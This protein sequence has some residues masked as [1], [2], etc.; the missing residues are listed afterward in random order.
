MLKNA[1]Q[2]I[3]TIDVKTCDLAAADEDGVQPESGD[4]W[5]NQI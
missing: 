5:D 2:N 1:Q 3:F 4:G